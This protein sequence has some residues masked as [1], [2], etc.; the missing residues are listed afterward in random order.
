MRK[1]LATFRQTN[2]KMSIIETTIGAKTDGD[3]TVV[4]SGLSNYCRDAGEPTG[5][6]VVEAAGHQWRVHIHPGGLS[7]ASGNVSCNLANV[8]N[9][10][11]LASFSITVKDDEGK[12]FGP[13]R[14]GGS[15]MFAAK[16]G[17]HGIP[18]ICQASSTR[19]KLTVFVS[20]SVYGPRVQTTLNATSSPHI[21]TGPTEGSGKPG[22]DLSLL[23][24]TG[25]M[26][27]FTIAVRSDGHNSLQNK[28][29]ESWVRIPVHRLVLSIRSPV[30][31][32]M[33]N[34]GLRESATAELRITDFD[35][36]VVQDFVRFL[37]TGNC[38]ATP[39]AEQLLA[40][41]HRYQMP[42]LQRLC[43]YSLQSGLTPANALDVL[44]LADL[45]SCSD[46]RKAVMDY[47]ARNPAALLTQPTFLSGLSLKQSQELLRAIAEA[48]GSAAADGSSKKP[49]LH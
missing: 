42:D 40:L 28:A 16:Y 46:L 31:K 18:Q 37:Y 12:Q 20:V 44:A 10:P 5:S 27:D 35:V 26:S 49:R 6:G 22:A 14:S 43:E 23:L 41:A 24:S 45:Y 32:T 30:L 36:P 48:D 39:H 17:I 9:K 11:A 4:F 33:L 29:E 13:F 19:N 1:C 7:S 15:R 47:I 3:F 38:D 2:N 21:S 34:V 25:Q 8:S